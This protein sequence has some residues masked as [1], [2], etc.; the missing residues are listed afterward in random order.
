M[1]ATR[2]EYVEAAQNECKEAEDPRAWELELNRRANAEAEAR[3][4]ALLQIRKRKRTEPETSPAESAALPR[5]GL[6]LLAA[7]RR[8]LPKNME[9]RITGSVGAGTSHAFSDIDIEISAD[10][11]SLFKNPN[12]MLMAIGEQVSTLAGLKKLAQA[13]NAPHAHAL[14]CIP[15]LLQFDLPDG[16]SPW[17]SVD[18]FLDAKGTRPMTRRCEWMSSRDSLTK[19]LGLRLSALLTRGNCSDG[20]RGLGSFGCLALAAAAVE[21]HR[22]QDPSIASVEPLVVVATSLLRNWGPKGSMLNPDTGTF[23]EAPNASR[24]TPNLKQSLVAGAHVLQDPAVSDNFLVL[25]NKQLAKVLAALGAANDV[26]DQEPTDVKKQQQP[27]HKKQRVVPK[28]ARASRWTVVAFSGLTHES[29]AAALFHACIA[30]SAG[31]MFSKASKG[32]PEGIQRRLIKNAEYGVSWVEMALEKVTTGKKLKAAQKRDLMRRGV[33]A[34]A[35]TLIRAG[36]ADVA[37]CAKVS[38]IAY[39]FELARECT[40]HDNFNHKARSSMQ[41]EQALQAQEAQQQVPFMP[42]LALEDSQWSSIRIPVLPSDLSMDNGLVCFANES[43]LAVL[44]EDQLKIGRVSR[45]EFM[46]KTTALGADHHHHY[47]FRSA[48]VHFDHW[49]N[50][51]SANFVRQTIADKGEFHCTGFFVNP[52]EFCCFERNR[53]IT[54]KPWFKQKPGG[55]GH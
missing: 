29:A 54:L 10:P 37:L 2:D 52:F 39:Q 40:R 38:G 31:G 12:A 46:N 26:H 36:V 19:R 9:V 1:N 34:V 14:E 50:N 17:S 27:K 6:A 25:Q 28:V 11:E 5:E 45:I 18:V 13:L 22:S 8:V 43:E 35:R 24:G 7:L 42:S 44:F 33:A 53:F 3:V 16:A 51:H 20:Y 55:N 32:I 23:S 47:E 49:F 41:T 21:A 4:A 30:R 48:L 15:G